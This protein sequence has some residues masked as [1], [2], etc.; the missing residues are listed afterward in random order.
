VI[1]AAAL[2]ALLAAGTTN[3]DAPQS[4]ALVPQT[5]NAEKMCSAEAGLCLSIERE[6]EDARVLVVEEQIKGS[7][8]R[9]VRLPLSAIASYGPEISGIWPQ[10][11]THRVSDTRPDA[12][13][14]GILVGLTTSESQGYSGGGAQAIR[15]HLWQL[16]RSYGSPRL[17]SEMLDVPLSGNV[18]IRACFSENDME[19]RGGACHDEYAHEAA[20]TLGKGIS[21][22]MPVLHYAFQAKAFPS[23]VRR[24]D[25]SL[26]HGKVTEKELRWSDDPN[27]SYTRTLRVNPATRRYE[28]DRAAPDC[29]DY[30]VP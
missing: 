4:Y 13:H 28:F 8:P 12:P 6:S 23:F 3:K 29:S 19:E 18:M 20:L 11:I 17:I 14:D 21:D 22:A 7:E 1:A 30:T 26:K 10:I 24:S 16:Y 2:A 9:V 25:D 5:D 27:C 15:V